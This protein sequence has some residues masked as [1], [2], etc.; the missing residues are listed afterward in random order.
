MIFDW[1]GKI[2]ARPWVRTLSQGW[3]QI[4]TRVLG[5]TVVLP[6]SPRQFSVVWSDDTHMDAASD[7]YGN[8]KSIVWSED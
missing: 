6:P 3:T 4:F 1:K 2:S 5:T 7:L 8:A